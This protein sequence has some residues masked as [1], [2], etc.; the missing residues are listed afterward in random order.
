MRR[1]IR[2][3]FAAALAA[4]LALSGCSK[5]KSA[6]Q[7]AKLVMIKTRLQVKKLWSTDLGGG[8]H[9]MLLHLGLGPA[10]EGGLV[11][12]ASHKGLVEALRV[13]NGRR[14]WRA[15]L[16]MP[17]SA[18]PG[19]GDGLVVVGSTQ[20]EIV[21]LDAGSG[22]VRWRTHVDA[23]LL[24]APAIGDS[25]VVL[26]SVDGRLQA[27]DENSGKPIWSIEQQVPRLS[28]RGIAT[29]VIVK[30]EVVSGFDNGKIVAV[31]INNGNT[32]WSTTLDAPRGRTALDRLVD[33]DCGVAV[34]GDNLYATGYHGRTAQLAI[35]SGQI[36]W[37]HNMSSDHGLAAD[38]K[39]VYVSEAD[40]SVVALRAQDGAEIWH[41][42]VLKWRDLSAPAITS[43]AIVVGDY[44]GY[45]H[46]MDKKTGVIIART[47][48]SKFRVSS[49]PIAIGNTVIVMSDG[50]EVAAFRAAPRPTG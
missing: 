13:T 2:L 43:A 32:L 1:H 6:D 5:D 22:Q 47:R 35:D 41:N 14:V 10:V 7:P 46:W 28:L 17:I 3:P 24:S 44:Q 40:G 16:R 48:D 39:T 45:L 21:A 19:T 25:V 15:R 26:R 4:L 18:G 20:G 8:K 11:Y 38:A 27:F 42:D 36:W 34:V 31:N 23:E 50:G 29:P 37:A 12:A 49:P 33:V 30:H 9:Q